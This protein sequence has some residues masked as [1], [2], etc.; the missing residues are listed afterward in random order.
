[1]WRTIRRDNPVLLVD[2]HVLKNHLGRRRVSGV[3][4]DPSACI[5]LHFEVRFVIYR[6]LLQFSLQFLSTTFK[7]CGNDVTTL[8]YAARPR[9]TGMPIGSQQTC[10]PGDRGID[11]GFLDRS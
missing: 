11:G 10:I 8:Q 3:G 4:G 2:V 1:M 7:L 6:T 5:Y 9:I